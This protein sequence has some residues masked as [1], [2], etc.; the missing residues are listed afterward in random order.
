MTHPILTR[1]RSAA[2]TALALGAALAL[3]GCTASDHPAAPA[4]SAAASPSSSA[5]TKTA[6]APARAVTTTITKPADGSTVA[7]PRVTV[8]GTGTAFEGTLKWRV[9]RAGTTSVVKKSFTTA[10]ANGTI[11]PFSFYVQ[12]A[13]GRYTLEVWEPAEG[14]GT[15]GPDTGNRTNLAT[16]TFTVT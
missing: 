3:A 10:G 13:P 15:E 5:P 7:G 2:I 11:G 6:P 4:S 8:K 14:E 16:S 9:L 12:L 1:P